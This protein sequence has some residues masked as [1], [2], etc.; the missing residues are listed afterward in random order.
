MT[1]D[2]QDR[3]EQYILGLQAGMGDASNGKP[4]HLSP[5]SAQFEAGYREGFESVGSYAQVPTVS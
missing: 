1:H 4:F 2:Q 5:C 3:K